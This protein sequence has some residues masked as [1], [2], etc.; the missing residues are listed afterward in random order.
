MTAINRFR[1]DDLARLMAGLF[2]AAGL[3]PAAAQRVAAALI[4]ADLSG[5]GSHGVL[6]ADNYLSRLQAGAMST[7]DSTAIV[8]ESAGAIVLDAQRIEGHLAAEDAIGIGVDR[9]R[10]HGIAAVAVRNGFHFGVAGRYARLA[11]E[12]EC[13]ALVMC[14]TKPVMAAPGGAER[15]MGTNPLAI[16]MPT[17][18]IPFVFDMAT[19]TGSFGRIRQAN[20]AGRAIPPDWALDAGGEPTTDAAAA[21]AGFL[22][23][24]AGAKGFGLAMAIDML[25]GMLAD[26]GWGAG[27]GAIEDDPSR[28]TTGSYLFIVID[29]GH[30][31]TPEAFRADASAAGARVRGSRRAPG[32]DQLFT[33]GERSAQTLARSDGTI[34]LPSPVVATLAR[35]AATLVVP[36]P[37][38]L[39]Q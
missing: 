37:P 15:L 6:Q 4:E 13:V 2:A 1:A 21:M 28:P 19:S 31:R 24:A 36:M 32:T 34:G 5:R 8:S 20:A 12:A 22:L 3:A 14:N 26:G 35:W 39:Q 7:G 17:N 16:G 9:A 29:I 27:L 18:D 23:P 30:F 33:P 25:S 38:S 10:R 11:A